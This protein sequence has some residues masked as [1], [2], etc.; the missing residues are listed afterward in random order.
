M[1]K[2][3][4]FLG[5]IGL[6]VLLMIVFRVFVLPQWRKRRG[7]PIINLL[8]D[9]LERLVDAGEPLPADDVRRL[10]RSLDYPMSADL[11]RRVQWLLRYTQKP[12]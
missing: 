4:L 7:R 5:L 8:L 11:R 9:D 6:I 3:G 10:Q 12:G 1:T 2:V